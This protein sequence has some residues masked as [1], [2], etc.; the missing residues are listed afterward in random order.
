MKILSSLL[1]LFLFTLML[2]CTSEPASKEE[3]GGKLKVVCT[4]GMLGDMVENLGGDLVEVEAL[5]GAGVDPHLYKATP[6]DLKKL[7]AADVIIYNGW[8]LEGKMVE[9]LEK[10]ESR[11]AVFAAS[12]HLPSDILL[13]IGDDPNAI[14][15]HVWFDVAMW[16][17][18][19][20]I[21]SAFLAEKD[22]EHKEAYQ[23][24]LAAYTDSLSNLNAWV[25]KEIGQIPEKQR[26]LIT[27]H[28]AFSYFGKAYGIDVKG[29]QGIS[30][31][32][33]F[34][35]KDVSDMV[36]FITDRGIKAVFVESSIPQK[37]LEAVVNGCAEKGHTVSIGGT[38]FSDAM[39]ETG[40]PQGTYIGMVKSNVTTLVAALK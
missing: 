12:E 11:K 28:D 32:A 1:S 8:H 36:K 37:S 14:D 16:E 31:V 9:V 7:R 15:P 17:E 21:V 23:K 10:L 35:I 38:L 29:L 5:M 24:N 27:A 3:D 18:C 39:G 4:T 25:E 26:V 34:G 33:E 13:Q 20:T 40:T 22:A 6:G 2:S 30:T 19:A